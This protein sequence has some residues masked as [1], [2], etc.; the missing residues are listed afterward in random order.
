MTTL[1]DTGPLVAYL[2]QGDQHHEWAT[3]QAARLSPPFL[4]C[5]AVLSEADFLLSDVPS[6]TECLLELLDRDVIH[7][8]F[9]YTAHTG[10][11][12]DLVRTYSDLPA[13]F[14]DACLVRMAEVH[15]DARVFTV[16]SDFRVYQKHGRAPIPVLMP[17]S[18][19]S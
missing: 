12:H 4:T 6:G 3:Q 15:D 5:E 8:P 7:A 11:V 13:S 2:Y 19:G 10:R 18:D 16:D 17:P 14:A 1:L 9:S